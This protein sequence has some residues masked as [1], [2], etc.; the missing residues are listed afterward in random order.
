MQT[1][2]PYPDFKQ[3]A[4]C[5]DRLRLGKQRVEVL[6]MLR[7]LFGE[8]KGYRNHPATLMWSNSIDNLI[9]YGVA[10]CEEWISRGYNDQCLEKIESYRGTAVSIPP[11]W[12]GGQIH[13]SHRAALL[14]KDFEWYSKFGWTE[15]PLVPL[16]SGSLPYYWPKIQTIRWLDNEKT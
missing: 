2:L 3:S 7:A 15:E 4:Q 13:A 12:L 8:T 1:F 16:T 9:D 14:H 6:Q 11:I 10:V 5:L